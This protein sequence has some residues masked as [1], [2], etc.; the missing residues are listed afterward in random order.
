MEITELQVEGKK[1]MAASD[2]LRG[3]GLRSGIRLG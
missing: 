1:R 3:A 2:F